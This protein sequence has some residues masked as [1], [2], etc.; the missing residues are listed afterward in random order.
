MLCA[1]GDPTMPEALVFE[2]RQAL[3]WLDNGVM[4]GAGHERFT[5]IS[6]DSRTLPAGCL[7]IPLRGERFDGHDF[8]DQAVDGAAAGYLFETVERITPPAIQVPDTKRA[9]GELARGWRAQ[10]ALPVMA[11]LGSNGKTTVKEMLASI[12]ATGF[13][14]AASLA[15]QGNLNND[16]GVPLTV[17]RLNDTHQAAVIELGMNHPGEIAWLAQIAQPGIAVITNAQREHQEFLDGVA[18]TAHENGEAFN[19]LPAD[20]IAVYPGDDECA[21]IWRAL[22]G[23]R[24]TVQFGYAEA[25]DRFDVWATPDSRADQF[26]LHLPTGVV[27]VNLQIAGRHNVRNAMAAAATAFAAGLDADVI[28][29]GLQ[30]FAPAAGRMR[31]VKAPRGITLIDDTY[32]ANPDSVRAAIDVLADLSGPRVLVL[33]DM[34][35]VGESGPQWHAEVGEYARE[36]GIESLLAIGPMSE[37]TV[38][39]FGAGG[40]HFES[41]EVICRAALNHCVGQVNVL[42]KGSRSMR[43]ERV[44]AAIAHSDQTNLA[45]STPGEAH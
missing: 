10:F 3:G 33:G 42:V 43:M 40:E 8:I 7:Y 5:A 28:A 14:E 17:F 31:P 4:H 15:T 18:A 26:A 20:G 37:L 30:A 35:E 1:S 22:A 41:I 36:Q 34:A 6:T 12:V 29:A 2:L 24:R 39:A 16:I 45:A 27:Q 38:Q 25:A 21:P 11:V 19:G 44:V 13:G 9:L 23:R 32:N